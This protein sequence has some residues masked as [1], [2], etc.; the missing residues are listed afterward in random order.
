MS[1]IKE[2]SLIAI[3]SSLMGAGLS[4]GVGWLVTYFVFDG[5]WK[6]NL[7]L[8]ALSTVALTA[9]ATLL[10]VLATNRTLKSK[11]LSLLSSEAM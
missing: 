2:F 6:P 10:T 3:A 7:L 8:A 11:P 4:V 9:M 5:T 1:L